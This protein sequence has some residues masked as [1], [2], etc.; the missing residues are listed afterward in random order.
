MGHLVPIPIVV[1]GKCRQTCRMVNNG[2]L[3]KLGSTADVNWEECVQEGVRGSLK[4]PLWSWRAGFSAG[5][6]SNPGQVAAQADG[7]DSFALC[8]PMGTM[9]SWAT[10]EQP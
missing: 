6:S 7:V 1:V 4:C 8:S 3:V 2:G 9:G 10:L 5:D